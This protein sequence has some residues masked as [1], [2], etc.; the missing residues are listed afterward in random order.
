MELTTLAALL[1]F[2]GEG[3]SGYDVRRLF[4]TTPVGI[5]S[6]SPGA[7]YPALA[8]LERAGF[9]A[10]EAQPSARRRR[11]YRRTAA[12]EA[13]LTEWLRAP[14]TRETI[15][16]RPHEI[17]LRYVLIAFR[18]GR[19]EACRFLDEAA[20]GFAGRVADLEAFHA[21]NR[22]MGGPSLDALDLGARLFRTRLEWCR[23]TREKWEKDG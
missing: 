14:I 3:Q 10:S 16:R 19:A 13:A 2:L 22:H 5:F 1:L 11:I 7:I 18:F 8:R 6:D 21:A 17:E 20:Q 12:G 15:E 23:A 9:F 4:Q